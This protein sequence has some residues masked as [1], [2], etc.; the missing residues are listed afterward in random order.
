MAARA[1][2]YDPRAPRSFPQ[3]L[4]DNA[5][6]G[7]LA[8]S[9]AWRASPR[10]I[11]ASL[12]LMLV[13]ALLAPLQLA[14]TRGVIDR[15]TADLGLVLTPDTF[16]QRLPLGAWIAL[17]AVAVALGQLIQPLS[18]TFRSVAGDR[19]SA[20]VTERL[21]ETANRWH[22]VARFEDPAY[23]DD[24][25]RVSGQAG[26]GGMEVLYYG[27]RAV[28]AVFT[29][30][31][32]GLTLAGLHPLIPL[33]LLAA[34]VPVMARQWEF[35]DRM[36]SAIYVQTPEAERLRYC[37]EV[38]FI[39]GLA[40]DVRLYALGPFFARRYDA[41]FDLTMGQVDRVRRQLAL[42]VSLAGLF[43]AAAGGA[44]YL[45]LVWLVAR[46]EHTVGDLALYGGAALLLQARLEGIGSS[47][48]SRRR[49][50]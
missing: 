23:A 13:Q 9:L 30:A 4:A 46:G 44:V 41:F 14:L 31:A 47:A 40:K 38:P 2:P 25:N 21:I 5:R 49:P 8:V 7:R 45:Y 37:K 42:R 24:L 16:A 10:L 28:L 26:R 20:D 12:A 34:T 50:I 1:D 15:A 36:G 32:L 48:S 3:R 22:G 27:S 43:S 33:V 29:A 6:L 17:T 39:P 11:G 35:R 18:T 19:L